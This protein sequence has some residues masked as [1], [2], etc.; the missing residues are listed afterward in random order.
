M[1]FPFMTYKIHQD[2]KTKK[3]KSVQFSICVCVVSKINVWGIQLETDTLNQL[4]LNHNWHQE[5]HKDLCEV[6]GPKSVQSSLMITINL[7]VHSYRSISCDMSSINSNGRLF[8]IYSHR[9]FQGQRIKPFQLH[10]QF[11]TH[12]EKL[13]ATF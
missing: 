8:I 9:Y 12:I 7:L 5:A 11:S 6:D 13:L 10:F 2:N 4:N 1:W 3:I